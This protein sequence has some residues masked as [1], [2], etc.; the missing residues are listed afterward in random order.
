[1]P[2]RTDIVAPTHDDDVVRLGSEVIGGPL[3]RHALIGSH[4]WCTPMR[5]MLVMVFVVSGLGIISKQHCRADGWRA[6][7]QY[8]HG[9]YSDI[10]PLYFARGLADGDVPYIGQAKDKQV[11]YPVLTGLAMWT[12]AQF[13]PSGDDAAQRARHCPD[14]RAGAALPVAR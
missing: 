1:M 2:D 11:E 12:T 8:T 14:E 10:P 9:C 6:P 4:R 13:V 3:G 7:G 5:V